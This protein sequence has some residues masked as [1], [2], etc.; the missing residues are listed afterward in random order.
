[1]GDTGRLD[2]IYNSNPCWLVVDGRVDRRKFCVFNSH[3]HLLWG[4]WV[5]LLFEHPYCSQSSQCWTKGQ[6]Q[7]HPIPN[8]CQRVVTLPNGCRAAV[9]CGIP[10]FIQIIIE[11]SPFQCPPKTWSFDFGLELQWESDR[12]VGYSMCAYV[13]SESWEEQCIVGMMPTWNCGRNGIPGWWV[14]FCIG[15]V[16]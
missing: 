14:H 13:S 7:A 16:Q 4:R 9:E 3:P 12:R 5:I 2:S 6:P 11:L 8:M 15:T 10:T 1:M